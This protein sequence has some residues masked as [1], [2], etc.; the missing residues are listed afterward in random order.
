MGQ[1][2]LFTVRDRR[3]LGIVAVLGIY[4]ATLF[5]GLTVHLGVFGIGITPYD[6]LG[7]LLATVFLV[8]VIAT[9]KVRL[10]REVWKGVVLVGLL[11]L[12]HGIAQ[13]RSPQPVR[14]VTLIMQLLRSVG[15]FVVVATYLSAADIRR[16]NVG[17][18]AVTGAVGIVT[19]FVYGAGVLLGPESAPMSGTLFRHPNYVRS[20]WFTGDPN[21]FGLALLVGALCGIQHLRE[22]GASMPALLGLAVTIAALLTTLS[23]SVVG[24]FVVVTVGWGVCAFVLAD[25][26][27]RRT[28]VQRMTAASLASAVVFALVTMVGFVAIRGQG[29]LERFSRLVPN[30]RL[31]LWSEALAGFDGH[32]L[33]GTGLRSVE[34]ILGRY[35]HNSYVGLLVRGGLIGLALY[36]V[37]VVFVTRIG[38]SG[39]LGKDLRSAVPW[40]WSWIALLAFMFFFSYLYMPTAW[41]IPAVLIVGATGEQP[42]GSAA[43]GDTHGTSAARSE[44]TDA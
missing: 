19:L 13:L 11:V 7:F 43:V 23:R 31:T 22:T 25:G 4:V 5:R 24:L 17:I 42:A 37:F 8:D 12:V 39:L 41:L 35:V 44:V 30:E 9:G 34:V 36:A 28:L 29:V 3:Q 14:G 21:F 10:P 1:S 27:A 32:Y 26:S 40:L 33:F 6:V 15:L 20:E 18:F 2:S 38:F 16:V